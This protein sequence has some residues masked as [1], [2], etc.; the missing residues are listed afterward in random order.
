MVLQNSSPVPLSL[1][2]DRARVISA[3]EEWHGQLSPGDKIPTHTE[4]MKRFGASER[5][6]RHALKHLQQAGKLVRRQGAGTFVAGALRHSGEGQ[7]RPAQTPRHT[8]VL[9]AE[10]GSAYLERCLDLLY[11]QAEL[12]N[13]AVLCCPLRVSNQL[14]FQIPVLETADAR[15]L[16]VT[17]GLYPLAQQLHDRGHR[18]A[19]V[20]SPPPAVHSEVP[21]VRADHAHGGYVATKHLIDQGHRRLAFLHADPKVADSAR[22]AGHQRAL[23]EAREAGHAVTDALYL[24][25]QLDAWQA[26]PQRM[27]L[28]L[29]ASDAPTGLVLWNDQEALKLLALLQKAGLRVPEDVSGVGYDNL[30]ESERSDPPLTTVDHGLA[31]QV[32]AAVNLLTDDTAQVLCRVQVVPALVPRHSSGPPPELSES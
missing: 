2:E 14:D 29:R 32:Q 6:V 17:S 9:V 18:V 4:L 11:R 20:G 12:L 21:S 28:D 31:Q 30:P 19:L 23:R 27:A 1:S 7:S 24:K 8:L 5:T 15:F 13:H 26:D 25:E 16:V 3:L 10:I 22:W